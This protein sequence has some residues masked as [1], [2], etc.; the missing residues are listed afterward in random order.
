MTT[1]IKVERHSFYQGSAIFG[2][3]FRMGRATEKTV[4]Q[5]PGARP[6]DRVSCR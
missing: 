5:G 1:G 2:P 3:D 6:V 4:E